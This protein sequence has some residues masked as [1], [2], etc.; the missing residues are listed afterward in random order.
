MKNEKTGFFFHPSS[1]PYEGRGS[2][3]AARPMV[4]RDFR[5]FDDLS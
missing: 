4:L 1:L 2:I 5:V 3:D